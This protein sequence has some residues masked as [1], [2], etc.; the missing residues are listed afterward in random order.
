MNKINNN[1][2]LQLLQNSRYAYISKVSVVVKCA[3]NPSVPFIEVSTTETSNFA[4]AGS[5]TLPLIKPVKE[6]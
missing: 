2:Y 3:I 6:T 1:G 5:N 4:S